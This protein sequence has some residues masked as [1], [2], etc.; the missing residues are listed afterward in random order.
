MRAVDEFLRIVLYDSEHEL[1]LCSSLKL[2]SAISRMSVNSVI[3]I[4]SAL[5]AFWDKVRVGCL[6][7]GAPWATGAEGSHGG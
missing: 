5:Q 3:H 6:Q 2:L 4:D 1:V 7:N